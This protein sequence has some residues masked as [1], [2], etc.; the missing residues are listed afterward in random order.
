MFTF[1]NQF[2]VLGLVAQLMKCEDISETSSS[3]GEQRILCPTVAQVSYE[4][5][6]FHVFCLS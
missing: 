5:L 4:S 6:E 3:Q 1:L 2:F